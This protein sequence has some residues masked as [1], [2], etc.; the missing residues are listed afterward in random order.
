ME[1]VL[2]LINQRY[3]VRQAIGMGGMGSVYACH[4]RLTGEQVAL[5]RVLLN[6]L[7]SS[8]VSTD[9]GTDFRRALAREFSLLA[10]L[11]HPHIISVLDYGFGADKLPF[12]TM[13]LLEHAQT[14][15]DYGQG[16]SFDDK[17]GLLMQV[18]QALV[19]LHRRGIIHRDLKPD[20]ILVV[21]GQVKVI[22]F[23]LATLK[24]RQSDG[25]ETVGTL[26]YIAPESLQGLAPHETMDIYAL[27]VIAYELI[28]EAY[29]YPYETVT[30][31]V[32]CIL[33]EA[34]NMQALPA[35]ALWQSIIGQ[36]LEK[37]PAQRT[38]SAAHFLSQ[39]QQA[40]GR[41]LEE[42]AEVRESFLQAARFV[43]RDEEFKLLQD[44]LKQ[45][46]QGMGGA[47]LIGGE[48]GVGKSRLVDEIRIQA[49]VDGMLVLRGQA[50]DGATLT[51]QL[52]HDAL[53][54]LALHV[55]LSDFEASVL[56]SIIPNFEQ[57][58]GRP[59]TPAPQVE[60]AA[61]R[62]RLLKVIEDVFKRNRLP[63]LII[64]EDLQ[65]MIESIVILQRL[66]ALVPN[67]PLLIIGNYR[68]DERPRLSQELPSMKRLHLER[69]QPKDIAE[70]SASMLGDNGRSP[71]V[72][73]LLQRETE[74]NAFFIVEV[75]RALAEESGTLHD[76]ANRTLPA[77][78]FA[79]GLQRVLQRRLARVP[80]AALALLKLAAIRGRTLDMPM[81]HALARPEHLGSFAN[82]EA[83]LL[84]CD[85][86]LEVYDERWRF[87]H[88]KLREAILAALGDDERRQLNLTVAQALEHA[89]ANDIQYATLIAYH[90]RAGG[91]RAKTAHYLADAGE[92]A[93]RASSYDAA[94]QHLSEALN[95]FEQD[96]LS[97]NSL[98]RA[99]LYDALGRA[100][101]A[102]TRF[103]ESEAA[104]RHALQDYGKPIQTQLVG[105]ALSTLKQVAWYALQR[106]R[107]PQVPPAERTLMLNCASIYEQLGEI[108]Y[109]T[110][111]TLNTVNAVFK[112]LNLAQ[113][114]CGDSPE[115]AI[116]HAGMS[117]LMGTLTLHRQA[118]Y[119]AQ[120]AITIA[121]RT[122]DPAALGW[123]C[124]LAGAQ[125]TTV[126]RWDDALRHL[127]EA[128]SINQRIGDLR[129]W[130]TSLSSTSYINI[131]ERDYAEGLRLAQLQYESAHK[132]G[133]AQIIAWA[134][135]QSLLAQLKV[136]DV[137]RDSASEL[138]YWL[139]QPIGLAE[140]MYGQGLVAQA[141]LQLGEWD[142][143]RANALKANQVNCST[144][145][146][147]FYASKGYRG[148]VETWLALAQATRSPE[149]KRELK[150]ALKAMRAFA[151]IF[152]IGKLDEDAV[153]ARAQAVLNSIP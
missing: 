1:A 99:R 88:D 101:L 113:R 81:L 19:Y 104:F 107:P 25:D 56:V 48:S 30:H 138:E 122:G 21:D 37:D 121:R 72:V 144:R 152:P 46:Q 116:N 151:N 15:L 89:Y 70:L 119:H 2:E 96:Q 143:A 63:T 118:E 145:P 18:A 120:T 4:D 135:C 33:G 124:F 36:L 12:Y 94:I 51:Y 35:P 148:A 109:F 75:V 85:S 153:Q 11:R 108:Y 16:R 90:Y 64:L 86:V 129:R 74:G 84:A 141:Y 134:L 112:S 40:L 77:T 91:E 136:N 55:E 23:G 79:G 45:A 69:L 8:A 106:W 102:Q 38:P 73:D 71:D 139:E 114:A 80:H 149:D 133:D 111:A 68:D 27:G 97:L 53:R 130:E 66:L 150:R 127:E 24:I 103:P 100:Y 43:G 58:L 115:L 26:R 82:L 44:A 10:S 3:E 60:A 98:H 123:A 142:F 7:H 110:N 29:P 49:L 59:I 34:I 31:L 47:W 65:W 105:I 6:E 20:N 87:A 17:L 132:R 137:Q 117:V 22:D 67:L 32:Q 52:W 146:T 78:I 61:V 57:L 13:E 54:Q 50:I 147:A 39:C 93:L 125:Y 128:I 14:I 126:A 62:L 76:V 95:I 92:N 140:R 28:A 9:A 131:L 41:P 42:D 83:W 5:K